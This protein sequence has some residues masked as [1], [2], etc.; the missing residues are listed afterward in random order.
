MQSLLVYGDRLSQEPERGFIQL[1]RFQLQPTLHGF[2]RSPQSEQS[3]FG[4][5]FH[6]RRSIADILLIGTLS[7]IRRRRQQIWFI[8]VFNLSYSL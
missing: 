7:P 4:V 6:D 5:Y 2:T 1:Q 8:H 3:F